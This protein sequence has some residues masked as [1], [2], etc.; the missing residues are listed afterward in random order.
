VKSLV[1][2]P[3]R[4]GD[5]IGVAAPAGP[6]R[7]ES[8]LESGLAHLEARGYAPVSGRHLKRRDGYLAGTDVER[9]EDLNRLIADPSIAAIWVARGGYGCARIIDG[10]DL[11]PLKK[12]PK[13][14]VGF[15]DATVLHAAA[16]RR[17]RLSTLY[18]PNV[19]ELGNG[20][21]FDETSLWRSLAAGDVGS[22]HDLPAPTIL[23]PGLGEGPLVGGCLSLLVSLIGTPAR[24]ARGNGRGASGRLPG[25]GARE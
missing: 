19:V 13:F 16:F 2:P 12:R 1:P 21:A 8:D 4:P 7:Q 9:L 3:L 22:V 23:R 18:G 15:S 24:E 10:V 11:A 5:R 20:K 17:L 6:I 14:L 25:Q